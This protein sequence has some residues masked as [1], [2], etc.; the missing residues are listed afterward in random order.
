MPAGV[1]TIVPTKTVLVGIDTF[2][3][4]LIFFNVVDPTTRESI[5]ARCGLQTGFSGLFHL[6]LLFG[7]LRQDQRKVRLTTI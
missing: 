6:E 4:R 2:G 3:V 7:L 5:Q 1:I